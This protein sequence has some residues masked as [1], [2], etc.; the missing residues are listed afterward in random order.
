LLL[1]PLP[2]TLTSFQATQEGSVVN[3]TWATSI[4]E[5][6]KHFEILRS[7]N[8]VDYIVIGTV[9]PGQTNYLFIDK[10]PV[11]GHNYYRLRSVDADGSSDYS[12]I[13][14]VN[15]KNGADVISSLYPNPATGNV[16]LKLQGKVEGNVLVQ[17]LDQQGRLITTKQFGVQHSEAFK[18]PL[19]LG[20]LST[21]S[22]V[23]RIIVNDKTYLQR[24]MIK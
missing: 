6:V 17:V 16:T 12:T 5:H 2:V 20:R 23:L 21:G 24:L 13:V 4:E 18:A 3:V 14:L 15:L 1:S 9:K 7:T 22:Y 11:Q 10:Q 19:D 8:G